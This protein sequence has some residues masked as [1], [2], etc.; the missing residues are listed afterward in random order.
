MTLVFIAHL[1]LDTLG[2]LFCPSWFLKKVF[3]AEPSI[4][5]P[6]PQLSQIW[7]QSLCSYS[8]SQKPLN[9]IYSLLW[10]VHS[11]LTTPELQVLDALLFY[12]FNPLWVNLVFI[13]WAVAVPDLV[14]LYYTMFRMLLLLPSS[15]QGLLLLCFPEW[16]N[17][18]LK[19]LS[20]FQMLFSFKI[21]RNPQL[22]LKFG[23]FLCVY[24]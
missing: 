13:C 22:F 12:D 6:I 21:G 1:E 2:V 5:S 3:Q 10:A 11:F 17:Q 19:R 23:L 18:G 9:L 24:A 16:R 15:P 4:C 14:L 8:Q 7:T 20:S